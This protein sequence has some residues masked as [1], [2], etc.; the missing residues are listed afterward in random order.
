MP[1]RFLYLLSVMLV[2]VG[3][4]AGVLLATRLTGTVADSLRRVTAPC[5]A[6]RMLD[7]PGL[8]TIF[9]EGPS[10]TPQRQHGGGSIADLVI[11][12]SPAGGGP[13]LPLAVPSVPSRYVLRGHAGVSILQ[14]A[15]QEPGRYRLEA[16]YPAGRSGPPVVL[17][18]GRDT[19]GALLLL[20]VAAVTIGL[21]GACAGV[22]LAIW[23]LL[24]RPDPVRSLPPKDV[25]SS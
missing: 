19:V 8:W 21:A 14:V 9:R 5:V 15:I 11:R 13:P 18:I 6:R 24:G 3:P 12:L 1:A 4:G 10:S 16:H 22:A 7:Q 25:R 17:A 2:L 23:T 20:R